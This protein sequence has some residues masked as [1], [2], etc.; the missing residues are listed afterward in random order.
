MVHTCNGLVV[1]VL[2]LELEVPGSIL[3]SPNL[4]QNPRGA[5]VLDLLNKG[6]RQWS[7]FHQ[8]K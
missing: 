5:S 6:G 8:K 3:I 1:S 4:S 2:G 7:C